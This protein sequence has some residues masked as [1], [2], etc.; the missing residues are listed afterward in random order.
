[1]IEYTFITMSALCRHGERYT[2]WCIGPSVGIIGCADD[3]ICHA[4]LYMRCD[5]VIFDV[6]YNIV[7]RLTV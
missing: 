3:A 4:E 2:S 6:I 1:M 5:A 7:L